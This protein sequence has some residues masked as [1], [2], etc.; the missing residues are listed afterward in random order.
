MKIVAPD[1]QYY[2]TDEYTLEPYNHN[3]S[4][5]NKQKRK[6]MQPMCI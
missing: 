2:I 4:K 6:I 1:A 5:Q 3:L